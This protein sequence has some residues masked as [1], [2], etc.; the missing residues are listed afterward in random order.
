VRRLFQWIKGEQPFGEN[1]G[2]R[3]LVPIFVTMDQRSEQ[4]GQLGSQPLALDQLPFIKVVAVRE[5]E[6]EQEVILVQAFGLFQKWQTVFACPPGF[7]P[8][9]TGGE[10]PKGLNVY[11]YFSVVDPQG[12]RVRR[13]DI[14]ADGP[15]QGEEAASEIRARARLPV[16]GPQERC[17]GIPAVWLVVHRE[18]CKKGNR[19]SAEPLDGP[20]VAV[21]EWWTE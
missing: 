8:A 18:V 10:P 7:V 17:K 6:S 13:K 14:R 1:N 15:V 4:F 16:V 11:R 5:R 21:E 12:I 9:T 3:R 19:F 20:A 2:V